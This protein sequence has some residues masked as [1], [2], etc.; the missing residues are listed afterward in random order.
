MR[1]IFAIILAAALLFAGCSRDDAEE[2]A[3]TL[4]AQ[5]ASVST[6]A[7]D[8][9]I[10]QDALFD[11]GEQIDVFVTDLMGE[12]T[13][14]QPQVYTVNGEMAVGSVTGS[15][16]ETNPVQFYPR[17]SIS[18]KAYYPQGVAGTTTTGVTT[19]DV[20]SDQ[21]AVAGYKASDLMAAS[22][23]SQAPTSRNVNLPFS[24]KLARLVVYLETMNGF[25]QS[26]VVSIKLAA[27]RKVDFNKG[28]FST[29]LTASGNDIEDVTIAGAGSRMGVCIVPPQTLEATVGTPQS[30]VKIE[31]GSGTVLYYRNTAPL[32]LVE[33]NTYLLRLNC[34]SALI[35]GYTTSTA[36]W[37]DAS[38]GEEL[39]GELLKLIEGSPASPTITPFTDG[40]GTSAGIGWGAEYD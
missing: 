18:I 7:V 22:V 8:D 16:M 38:S 11:L 21:S 31:L 23:P 3:I 12:I 14:A 1:K 17:G 30:I 19:F 40:T 4:A 35:T 33:G 36:S 37:V 5:S 32:Q 6:R 24:H 9:N 10:V 34:S 15:S 26:D 28:N 20:A 27:K 29:T 13:Y 39:L 25:T 2:V